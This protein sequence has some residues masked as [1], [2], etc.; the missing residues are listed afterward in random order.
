M[1]EDKVRKGFFFSMGYF[2]ILLT[3]VLVGYIWALYTAL[4]ALVLSV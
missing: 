3:P 4:G 2:Q 1:E